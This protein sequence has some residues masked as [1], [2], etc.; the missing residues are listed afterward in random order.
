MKAGISTA[1]LYPMLLEEAFKAL[2]VRGIKTIEIFVN[3]D[4]ELNDPY[5]S[6]MLDIKNEYGIDVAAVH[7]YT[8]AME[9]MMFFTVYERRIND[10]LLY[11][12]RFFEYMNKFGAKYFIFHG[13][14]SFVDSISD[15]AYYE[16]F[17]YIQEKASENGVEVLHENV[18]RPTTGNLDFFRKMTEHIGG[19]AK[20]ALDTKQAHR[21]F[22]DP[23]DF[24]K[25]L[26]SH[27]KHIH[28]SDSGT[29]GDCLKFGLGEYDNL[30]FFKEVSKIN[31]NGNIILELYRHSFNDPDELAGNYR[32]L[33]GYLRENGFC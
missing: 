24:I 12:K 13:N 8:C 21:M 17:A 32:E 15:E 27:I 11:Y 6:L 7:P 30:S 28:F 33:D 18:Y 23:V 5:L 2:A 10:M 22:C 1:C 14:K 19:K 3:T 31:F 16:R 29:A 9:P 4:R 26:G 25:V 20:F